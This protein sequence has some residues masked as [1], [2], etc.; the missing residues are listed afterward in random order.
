MHGKVRR[1]EAYGV[2]FGDL[3]SAATPTLARW[4]TVDGDV[5]PVHDSPVRISD[6]RFQRVDAARRRTRFHAACAVRQSDRSADQLDAC[7][8]LVKRLT[9]QACGGVSRYPF[10]RGG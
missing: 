7:H 6:G 2:T 5:S 8:T 10:I 3:L 9:R 1:A 4:R